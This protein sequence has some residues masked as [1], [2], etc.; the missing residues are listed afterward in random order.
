M[1]LSLRKATYEDMDLLFKW[2]NDKAVRCNAFNSTPIPYENHVKW[3]NKVMSDNT[4]LQ[5]IMCDEDKPV[6]QIRLNIEDGKAYI[7]YSISN[8]KRG[9]GLGVE[10]IKLLRVNVA[11]VH[12]PF[13]SLIG[14]VKYDNTASAKTFEKCGFSR[15]YK[16]QYIEYEIIVEELHEDNNCNN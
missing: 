3:F 16:E 1:N 6:G 15:T 7:D 11:G 13:K 14:Q 10:M 8:D 4:V 5:L 12:C 2:A 9:Q